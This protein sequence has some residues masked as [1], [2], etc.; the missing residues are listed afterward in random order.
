MQKV[1]EKVVINE[2][3]DYIRI[4]TATRK[5]TVLDEDG[6]LIKMRAKQFLLEF[7]KGCKINGIVVDLSDKG[8]IFKTDEKTDFVDWRFIKSLTRR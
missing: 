3:E 7:K 4:G 8:L 1:E 2:A 5:G 6:N